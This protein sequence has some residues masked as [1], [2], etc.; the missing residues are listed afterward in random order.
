MIDCTAI[1]L[2]PAANLMRRLY[3]SYFF[4]CNSAFRN[5]FLPMA[6]YTLEAM[7]QFVPFQGGHTLSMPRRAG[8]RRQTSPVKVYHFISFAATSKKILLNSISLNMGLY[9][10]RKQSYTK[11]YKFDYRSRD[12]TN[13]SAI[14]PKLSARSSRRPQTYDCIF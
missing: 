6:K 10:C 9:N 4:T 8:A 2:T 12:I 5:S 7:P 3:C 14:L 1:R 13:L 11:L